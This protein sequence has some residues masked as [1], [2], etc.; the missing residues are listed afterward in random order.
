MKFATVVRVLAGM[1]AALIAAAAPPASAG[2]FYQS[3]ADLAASPMLNA[4]CSACDFAPTQRIGEAFTLGSAQTARS[5]S[6]TVSQF[7]WPAD[8]DVAIYANDGGT[9]GA[10]LFLHHYSSFVIDAPTAFNTRVETVN[11]GGGVDLAAGDYL[12]FLSNQIN[13]GIPGFAGLDGIVLN[14]P[15]LPIAQGTT[16][17]SLQGA[18]IGVS[19]SDARAVG[20]SPTPEPAAWALMIA[21][22]GLAGATLRARRAVTA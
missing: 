3:T 20:G 15:D 21:G 16:F 6:F 19:L 11:L 17:S 14:S 1:G 2:T 10:N 5:A 9:V 18:D 8:V 12:I 7:L 22:F 13:L 4:Y